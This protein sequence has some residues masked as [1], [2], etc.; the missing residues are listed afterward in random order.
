MTMNIFKAYKEIAKHSPLVHCITNFVTMDFMANSLLAIGAAPV[1]AHSVEEVTQM[2]NIASSLLINIGTLEPEWVKAMHLAVDSAYSKSIPIVLDPVGSGATKY[3]TSTCLDLLNT[4]KISVV[5]GNA[6]EVISLCTSD[7][8][9]ENNHLK[10]ESASK[11]VESTH[12]S[13][14]AL[15]YAKNLAKKYNL[16]V[17]ISGKDDYITNGTQVISTHNGHP[18][19]KKVTGAGCVFS[20]VIAAFLSLSNT[21]LNLIEL[22]AIASAFYGAAGEI[23]A[24]D[25]KCLGPASFKQ[26]FIDKLYNITEEE[27]E[28]TVEIKY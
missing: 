21:K 22:C 1:M 27:L 2:T 7:M 13:S 28:N 3:R 17:V 5:R 20:A 8:M 26:L 23:A 10:M 14:D 9:E 12:D 19:M 6:S 11:G 25:E 16:I 4:R 24:H 18:L 15:T